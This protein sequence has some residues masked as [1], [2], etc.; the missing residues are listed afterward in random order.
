[1]FKIVIIAI[2][3]ISAGLIGGAVYYGNYLSEIRPSTPNEELGYSVELK[4]VHHIV[5]ISDEENKT[6]M[7]MIGMGVVGGLIGA[8]AYFATKNKE[9]AI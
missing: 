7:G 5:Y 6:L 4:A 2:I 3:F 9:N 8:I 1:M